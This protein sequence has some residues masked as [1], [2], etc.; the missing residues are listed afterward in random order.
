MADKQKS[1]SFSGILISIQAKKVFNNPP[2]HNCAFEFLE[3]CEKYN[4][5]TPSDD[6]LCLI[7][8]RNPMAI[9]PIKDNYIHYKAFMIKMIQ[10]AEKLAQ[11]LQK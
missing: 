11:Q 1:P 10:E 9:L 7:C 6:P 2:C 4:I 8:K 5:H 3:L